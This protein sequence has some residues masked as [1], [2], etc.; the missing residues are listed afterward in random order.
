[1]DRVIESFYVDN[2]YNPHVSPELLYWSTRNVY[3]IHGDIIKMSVYNKGIPAECAQG[4]HSIEYDYDEYHRPTQMCYK[5]AMGKRISVNGHH[6]VSKRYLMNK[7]D[8]E[9][10]YN[11]KD[12]CILTVNYFYDDYGHVDS[13]RT[14]NHVSN[15]RQTELLRL[16]LYENDGKDIFVIINWEE[17]DIS[18]PLTNYLESL[19][20]LT[21]YTPATVLVYNVT[22]N[23]Y[24][25]KNIDRN[26]R[27]DKIN[28]PDYVYDELL[29]WESMRNID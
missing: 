16:A 6:R 23:N 29:M 15:I 27:L 28:I 25:Y 9:I 20:N 18:Q 24:E 3:N 11:E 14:Q 4:Y 1:M 7:L 22:N 12:E 5:N 13:L 26:S 21:K 10:Y 17:W 2:I 8:E 19:L